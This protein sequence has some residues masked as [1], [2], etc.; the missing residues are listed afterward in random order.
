MALVRLPDGMRGELKDPLGPVHSDV[1]PGL[2]GGRVVTVGDIVTYHFLEAGVVPDVAVVDGR[3]ER[4]DVDETVVRRWRELPEAARV[5]NEAGTLSRELIEALREA[6][7]GEEAVRVE[8]VGEEDLAVLPAI[9]LCSGGDTVVYGQPGEG[10]VYVGVDGEVQEE[11]LGLLQR[12]DVRDVEELL[13]V[14]GAS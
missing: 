8:V 12:M 2:L 1:E 9:V 4:K 3:T 6:L 10:M 14:L 5:K 13:G 7:V 11:A